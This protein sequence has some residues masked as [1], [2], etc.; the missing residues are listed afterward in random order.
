M[1][2]F[3]VYFANNSFEIYT[4]IADL[5]INMGLT[6]EELKKVLSKKVTK[7]GEISVL[8]LSA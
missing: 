4:S 1:S 7:L 5:R 6:A 2:L 8:N 3:K